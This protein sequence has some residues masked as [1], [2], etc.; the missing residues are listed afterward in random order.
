M[1]QAAWAILTDG[2]A[3]AALA[4]V[5]LGASSGAQAAETVWTARRTARARSASRP[6]APSGAFP[7][8]A[9]RSQGGGLR[10]LFNTRETATR[11]L[12]RRSVGCRPALSNAVESPT[13]HHL[14]P[15]SDAVAV[16]VVSALSP[17]AHDR[18][19]GYS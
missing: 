15:V 18:P 17:P 19:R 5:G 8:Q 12:S 4:L 13:S 10:G 16:L 6:P 14:L 11:Q 2:P 7:A 9:G 1:R 3:L